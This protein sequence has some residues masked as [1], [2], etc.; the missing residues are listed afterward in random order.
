LDPKRALFS[1]AFAFA[2]AHDPGVMTKEKEA[3]LFAGLR[4]MREL[5]RR[6]LPFARSLVEFDLIIEIGYHEERGKPLT[7]KHLLTLGLCA[8]TTL[9]R[10]LNGLVEQG[11]LVRTRSE[12]DG[13]A[14]VLGVSKTASQRLQR[15]RGGIVASLLDAS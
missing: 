10:R 5:E 15:Y 4:R 2:A 1:I 13:R 11:V 9:N 12:N 8:R 3:S 14:V 6:H 7:F